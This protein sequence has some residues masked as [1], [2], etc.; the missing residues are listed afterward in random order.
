MEMIRL[1]KFYFFQLD[2]CLEKGIQ[3][4]MELIEQIKKDLKET[5]SEKRYNH[6]IGVMEMAEE[7]AK[8]YGAD[9]ETA[10]IAGLLHDIAKEMSSEEKLKYVE[11]NNIKIDEVERIN[12]PILHGKIG[13]D[14][15]AKKYGVNEQIQKAI[16]YH[17]T[18]STDMDIIAK[19]IYVSDKIELNRK[20]EDY[21]IEYER[22]LA[23]K[24]LDE[25]I[26]YIINSNITSLINK[27]KL[28]HPKSIET[29]NHLIIE[30]L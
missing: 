29:R 15:A 20:S 19:I 4:R 14:I 25:T 13:A 17:T 23:K 11:E 1:K 16:E 28:I 6:S 2:L 27:G 12:T 24:D 21:D 26:I 18:T 30:K 22:F 8:L 10:K 3:L 5:L 9:V 7:L